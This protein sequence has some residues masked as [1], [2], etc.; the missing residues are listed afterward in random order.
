MALETQAD[1]VSADVKGMRRLLLTV[2]L[3]CL[4]TVPAAGAASA[5]TS[6]AA[7][8]ATA[9][10]GGAARDAGD[11]ASKR[12]TA[13]PL[14]RWYASHLGG[15]ALSGEGVGFVAGS[16]SADGRLVAN[17][18]A[19]A[20][21]RT[22]GAGL[23]VVGNRVLDGSGRRVL[24]HGVN[25][26]SLEWSCTGQRLDGSAGIPAS[27]FTTMARSW[28]ATTVRLGLSEDK[29]LSAAE[30]VH[31][32][33]VDT[34]PGYVAAVAR[35]V[36]DA[37]AAGLTVI[38][39]LHWSDAGDAS[40]A[41][42]QQCAPDADSTR[43]WAS[44]ATRF[45]ADAKVVF[46]LYNEPHD[47]SWAVWRDG[48][49]VTCAGMSYQAV[50]MQFLLETVRSTGAANLVLAGA[51]RYAYDLSGVAAHPLQGFNVAYATHPYEQS[52]GDNPPGWDAAFG[53]LSQR[54][55][56]VATEIG[57][58]QCGTDAYDG[59]ILRYLRA[60]GIGYTAWAWWAGGCRFPSL[61]SSADGTCTA[62]GCS[63]QQ[64]L[65][66][67]RRG[68]TSSGTTPAQ[69]YG[70]SFED[71]ST[72]GRGRTW[73]TGISAAVVT[74]PSYHGRRELGVHLGLP[75][76]PAVGTSQG[77]SALSAGD[78]ATLHLYAPAG[79][80]VSAVP[81]V[82]D[83]SWAVHF[84]AGQA[85]HRGW[86]TITFTV[87]TAA[88]QLGVQL[89]NP[90]WTGDLALDE[91]TVSRAAGGARSP[92]DRPRRAPTAARPGRAAA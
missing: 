63:V 39:D 91:V 64:D 86:N 30:G 45:A 62:G 19:G 4:I 68:G 76:Y 37:E 17:P 31:V 10:P 87:P 88:N 75:G 83:A 14:A 35:T 36:T 34:C 25:R 66:A 7:P 58:L 52:A 57:T 26:P 77:L 67:W 60:R 43:F 33:T 84:A 47:V 2:A 6:P 65:L 49:V 73:G 55:P 51:L 56:V 89:S 80:S 3:S 81:Y 90:T 24:L 42:S 74:A 71:G 18:A 5:G 12:V 69:K 82:L 28:G 72:A 53:N 38:L 15:S 8:F 9:A 50:G 40:R 41:S 59:D 92:S 16:G 78:T 29:W 70:T 11:T 13:R 27:D 85:L 1:A 46:E 21:G 61:V 23:H 20:G 79:V 54:V 22:S 44:V 32:N 48:G